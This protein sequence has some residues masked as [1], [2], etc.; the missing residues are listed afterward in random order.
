VGLKISGTK[1]Q[2]A[3]HLLSA[4]YLTS[5]ELSGPPLRTLANPSWPVPGS[6]DLDEL[7][8][9]I[10]RSVGKVESQYLAEGRGIAR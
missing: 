5:M 4:G 8:R 2:L 7:A 6:V 1:P 3:A 9:K 10:E